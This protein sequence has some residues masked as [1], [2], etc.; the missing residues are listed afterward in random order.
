MIEQ[1]HQRLSDRF[2][3]HAGADQPLADLPPRHRTVRERLAQHR[4]PALAGRVVETEVLRRLAPNWL[5]RGPKTSTN[6]RRSS[7]AQRCNV[8][9]INQ[10]RTTERSSSN[11]RSTAAAVSPT[12]R[13]RTW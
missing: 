2:L 4:D 7:A 5:T 1:M 13:T 3:E 9:R 8:P 6:Q 12:L 10:V 11:A